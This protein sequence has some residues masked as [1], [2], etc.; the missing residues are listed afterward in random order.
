LLS[1][2]AFFARLIV[3]FSTTSTVKVNTSNSYIASLSSHE[4]G[5]L[6]KIHERTDLNIDVIKDRGG[7]LAYKPIV[8]VA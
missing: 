7:L 1:A 4:L 3:V 8:A 6:N 5:L 2:G